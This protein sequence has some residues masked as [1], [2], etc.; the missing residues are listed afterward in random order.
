MQQKLRETVNLFYKKKRI[1]LFKVLKTKS[2]QALL[3]HIEKPKLFSINGKYFSYDLLNFFFLDHH[4][5]FLT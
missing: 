2:I 5:L 3:Q 1:K 4:L